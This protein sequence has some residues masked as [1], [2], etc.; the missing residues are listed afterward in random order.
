VPQ[1][2]P[3]AIQP[4]GA[5]GS[6][7]QHGMLASSAPDGDLRCYGCGEV[8]NGRGSHL[9]PAAQAASTRA[10]ALQMR[11]PLSVRR[12]AGRLDVFYIGLYAHL[13]PLRPAEGFY[14]QAEDCDG[15][16]DDC[17]ARH[18]ESVSPVAARVRTHRRSLLT[19]AHARTGVR[20]WVCLCVRARVRVCLHR[21]MDVHMFAPSVRAL[22]TC[23]WMQRDAM[24]C[25]YVSCATSVAT[26]ACL[27]YPGR[28]QAHATA[29]THRPRRTT[30]RRWMPRGP[31]A[32]AGGLG[33][34]DEQ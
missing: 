5:A 29:A 10:P 26:G 18:A 2:L 19:Q 34:A 3:R 9:S 14:D 17:A 15:A 21:R 24:Q 12:C 13:L 1:T 27:A 20:V 22:R 23:V 31:R 8:G 7:A 33:R 6:A 11:A 16:A 4:G 28:A 32:A 30:G 25:T